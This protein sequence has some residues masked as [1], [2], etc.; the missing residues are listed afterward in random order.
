MK[1]FY[2]EPVSD[3]DTA[4]YE[5]ELSEHLTQIKSDMIGSQTRIVF[6]RGGEQIVLV[7]CATNVEIYWSD[8]RFRSWS[9]CFYFDAAEYQSVFPPT[10]YNS[11][12]TISVDA[13]GAELHMDCFLCEN[14][15][16]ERAGFAVV[17]K[18]ELYERENS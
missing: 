2:L 1:V 7:P 14:E 4:V 3:G 9:R 17:F 12:L 16:V 13:T 18:R 8:L 6:R 10:N 11:H 5:V 15:N